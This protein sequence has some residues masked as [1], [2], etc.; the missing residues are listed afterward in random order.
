L[1]FLLLDLTSGSGLNTGAQM[2]SS[3]FNHKLN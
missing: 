3:N 1:C 2:I